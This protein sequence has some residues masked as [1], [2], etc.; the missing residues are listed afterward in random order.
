MAA[1]RIEKHEKA[2]EELKKN[3]EIALNTI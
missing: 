3:E 1:E 2:I